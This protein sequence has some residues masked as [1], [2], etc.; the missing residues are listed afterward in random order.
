MLRTG[1]ERALARQPGVPVACT[2]GIARRHAYAPSADDEDDEGDGGGAADGAGAD[3][4]DDFTDSDDDGAL[5]G[6]DDAGADD[7]DDASEA[8]EAPPCEVFVEM[9]SQL[10][11]GELP[12]IQV[13]RATGERERRETER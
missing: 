2:A 5:A 8:G 4:Y 13:S 6:A 9:T 1:E 3:Y 7:D 10:K 12:P 11:A